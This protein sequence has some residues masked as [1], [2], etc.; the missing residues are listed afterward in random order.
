MA[1][2]GSAAQRAAEQRAWAQYFVE[3]TQLAAQHYAAR[4][5]QAAAPAPRPSSSAHWPGGYEDGDYDSEEDDEEEYWQAFHHHNQ[6]T[7]P[8]TCQRAE[9]KGASQSS[10]F[11]AA[12]TCAHL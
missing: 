9:S 12:A 5:A 6:T 2:A 7:C 11:S 4:A 1:D 10:D 8:S 3:Q